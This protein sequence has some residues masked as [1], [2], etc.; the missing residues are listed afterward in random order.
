MRGYTL[1]GWI[2]PLAMSAVCWALFRKAGF[3]GAIL[4]LPLLPLAGLLSLTLFNIVLAVIDGGG[5]GSYIL[6]VV[7]GS[8]FYLA[9]LSV[10]LM[11]NGP[12]HGEDDVFK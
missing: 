10:L 3:R 2:G 7:I 5:R 6:P 8:A 11:K 12:W 1:V 4:A 9:P